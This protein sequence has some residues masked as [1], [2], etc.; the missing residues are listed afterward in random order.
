MQQYLAM[1]AQKLNSDSC[2]SVAGLYL[3]CDQGICVIVGVHPEFL[4][5]GILPDVDRIP[6]LRANCPTQL[7]HA[8]QSKH[9]TGFT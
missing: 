6:A 1:P 4:G 9:R 7:S 2:N 5:L 3:G 8:T